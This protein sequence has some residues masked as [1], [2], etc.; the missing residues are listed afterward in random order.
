MAGISNK[1]LYALRALLEL[2]GLER[3]QARSIPAIAKNQDIPLKFLESIMREL[4][5]AG[6]VSSTRGKEGGYR[7]VLNPNEFSPGQVVRTFQ[8]PNSLP[9]TSCCFSQ[10][11][12]EAEKAWFDQFDKCSFRDV[13]RKKAEQNSVPDFSI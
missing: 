10:I 7:L 6:F 5:E 12:N 3:G 13:L 1:C 8:P 4:K 9:S 11:V 2:S